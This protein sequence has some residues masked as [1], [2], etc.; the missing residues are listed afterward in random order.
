MIV[1]KGM[2][3]KR[4]TVTTVEGLAF[5]GDAKMKPMMQGDHM[6]MM[7]MHYS[8]GAASPLHAHSHE[9]LCYVIRGQVKVVVGQDTYMLG[10]GDACKHPIDVLHSL[11]AIEDSVFLE[12]KS[13]PM[14]L[15]Q[16]L[17]T[18]K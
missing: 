3:V 9:S 13:P 18:S 5:R 4:H 8:A 6:I 17:G 10:A 16:F 1:S 12:I 7:E 14:P 2:E 15:D 11:E